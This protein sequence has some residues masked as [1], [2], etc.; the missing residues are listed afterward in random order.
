MKKLKAQDYDNGYQY[1][2]AMKAVK[3]QTQALR[4]QRKTKHGLWEREES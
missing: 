3:K 1:A 4:G 2:K